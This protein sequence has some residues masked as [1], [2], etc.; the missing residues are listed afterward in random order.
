MTF[1]W[2]Q[3]LFLLTFIGISSLSAAS[4]P[5]TQENKG[6][7]KSW[8]PRCV[9]NIELI[10]INQMQLRQ[11]GI[12]LDL[13]AF[14]KAVSPV[15]VEKT[16]AFRTLLKSLENKESAE[17]LFSAMLKITHGETGSLSVSN[18]SRDLALRI[19]PKTRKD[20]LCVAIEFKLAQPKVNQ[21]RSVPDS[22][23]FDF[24]AEL[25]M[26]YAM[27]VTQLFDGKSDGKRVFLVVTMEQQR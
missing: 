21:P 5:S 7:T 17:T 20:G 12:D 2:S 18:D 23:S 14:K 3:I 24:V 4:S 16:S 26:P 1:L 11:Q 10:E 9:C 15:E 27:D 25:G 22:V 8:S 13:G 6:E 19:V